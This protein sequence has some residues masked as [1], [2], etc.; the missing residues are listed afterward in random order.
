MDQ[1]PELR[2]STPLSQVIP[3]GQEAGFDIVFS[4][5]MVKSFNL[6]HMRSVRLAANREAQHV[7]NE[8]RLKAGVT[9]EGS[10][11]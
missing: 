6:V 10:R 4:S 7:G 11:R 5:Q 8:R 1:Y 9:D 2:N 3:P